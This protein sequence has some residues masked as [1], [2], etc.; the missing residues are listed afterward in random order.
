MVTLKYSRALSDRIQDDMHAA[1]GKETEFT[2]LKWVLCG[3]S[4]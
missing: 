1:R 2:E 4:H 3:D